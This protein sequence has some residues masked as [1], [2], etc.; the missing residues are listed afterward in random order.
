[1]LKAAD[2]TCTLCL[3]DVFNAVVKYGKVPEDWRKS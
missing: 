1:M 3:T 2:E